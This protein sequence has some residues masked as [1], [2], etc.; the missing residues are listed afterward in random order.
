MI[1]L[2][3]LAAIAFAAAAV[4]SSPSPGAVKKPAPKKPPAKAPAKPSATNKATAGTTQ[5]KGSE[6]KFGETWTLGK[7]DPWNFT[8]D[9][10][11]YM[12]EQL[13]IGDRI[14][15]PKANEKLL[16]LRFTV[17]NPQKNEALMRYDTFCFTVVDTK[18][19][20][21]EGIGEL[22]ADKGKEPYEQYSVNMKPAQKAKLLTAVR[23]P[24]A[25][26]MP[27]LIVKSSDDLV[28]R[29]DLRGQVK[30]FSAPFADPKDNTG[31]TL[32]ETVPGKIGDYYPVGDFDVKLDEVST[33][34]SGTFGDLELEEGNYWLILKLTARNE[35]AEKALLR[36]DTFLPKLT[37]EDGVEIERAAGTMYSASRNTDLDTRIDPGQEMKFRYVFQVAGD[38]KLKLFTIQQDEEC[39]AYV[40]D[41]S[42]WGK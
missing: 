31:L 22:G 19:Q 12:A 34:T 25:G 33:A 6:P 38:Q 20:N 1:K 42:S 8:L 7:T 35:T 41:A 3:K 10:A 29:Y 39:R 40:Y 5:L 28:L 9:S 26:V 15:C 18:D 2:M 13:K 23:V 27:K 11:E 21:W 37:D 17:H 16:L 36:Y 30:G 24:A 4:V 32:L 14:W